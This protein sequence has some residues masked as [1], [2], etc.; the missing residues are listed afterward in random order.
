[1]YDQ[2]KEQSLGIMNHNWISKFVLNDVKTRVNEKNRFE[3]RLWM[4]SK[5]I[6]SISYL[7]KTHFLW[8]LHCSRRRGQKKNVFE[9]FKCKWQQ[10]HQLFVRAESKKYG[11]ICMIKISKFPF[12][13]DDQIC[14]WVFFWKV[15]SLKSYEY[16]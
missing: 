4:H 3:W 1:M 5:F 10:E 13:L 16:I 2:G 12:G 6:D 14:P 15:A 9:I 11:W 8:T 7:N